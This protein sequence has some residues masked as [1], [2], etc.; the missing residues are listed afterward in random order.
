MAESVSRHLHGKKMIVLAGGGHIAHKYGIPNRAFR[1]T[2]AIFK[3]I[4]P[5]SDETEAELS[6]ADYLWILPLQSHKK[7]L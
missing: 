5:I 7:R 6:S 4:L 2:Q 3:T 1:R